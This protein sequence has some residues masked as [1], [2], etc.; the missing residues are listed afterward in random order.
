MTA[1]RIWADKRVKLDHLQN[2]TRGKYERKEGR[3][4][5]LEVKEKTSVLSN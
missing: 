3:S 4:W 5:E 2:W 1:F